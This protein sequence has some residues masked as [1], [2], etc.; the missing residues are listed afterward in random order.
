MT[1]GEGSGIATGDGR[2]A[3]TAAGETRTSGAGETGGAEA[4]EPGMLVLLLALVTSVQSMATFTVLALPTLATKA[5]STFGLGAETAGY[6][7]SVVYAAAAFSSS[8]A[9]LWVRRYGGVTTSVAAMLLAAAGIASLASGRIWP[10]IVGSVLIGAAYGLTNP[11]ASH[12]LFRFA[13]RH[14]QNLIFAL[15]QTGVPLGGMLAA[16]LLPTLAVG[17]GWQGAMLVGAALPL[18]LVLPLWLLRARIDADRDPAARMTGGISAGVRTVARDPRLRA[19]MVMG[20]S[21]ALLQFCLFTFLVTMLVEEMGW[22]IVASGAVATLM[23]AGGVA[24]RVAW[25]VLADRI[26]HARGVLAVIGLLS[27][28]CAIALAFAGPA[29]PPP[30]LTAVLVL[31]GF[32]VVGWNGLWMA[33]I[34]RTARPGEVGLATGGVLVFTY[35]GI[36]AGPAAFATAYKLIGSYGLTYAAFAAFAL[37]GAAALGTAGRRR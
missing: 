28:A 7:I 4:L 2:G 15:K 13:P 1:D 17:T 35:V 16:A 12:L 21:Y 33:E 23:Q 27:A 24:G 36:V 30:A 3:G 18:L 8:V 22:S 14:R 5:A 20:S 11:A 25:S 26:G 29:W 6:Q 10:A 19:M 31:F 34:A 9:G 37:I 32:S